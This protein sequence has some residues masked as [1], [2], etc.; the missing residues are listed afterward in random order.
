MDIKEVEL[1]KENMLRVM[2]RSPSLGSWGE[3]HLRG[4]QQN[5]RQKIGG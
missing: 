1:A 3:E 5:R 4:Q 2:S